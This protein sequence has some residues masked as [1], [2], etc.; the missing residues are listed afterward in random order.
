MSGLLTA[1]AFADLFGP[2]GRPALAAALLPFL[3]RQRWFGGKGRTVAAVEV[4]DAVPLGPA[5]VLA[6]V[7][8]GYA[9]SRSERYAAPLRFAASEEAQGA[10]VPAALGGRRGVLADAMEDPAV[11]RLLL[12]SVLEERRLRG[13]GGEVIGHRT[14]GAP[15]AG[16]NLEPYLLG[17][18]QSNTSVRFGRRCILKLLRRVE[19]GPH[20]DVEVVGFLTA[21]GFRHVPALIGWLAYRPA[22]EPPAAL[23]VVQAYV[24]N[25]GD[26]WT[27]ALGRAQAGL[28]GEADR[29]WPDE[30]ARLGRRTAELHLTLAGGTDPAFSPE[31]FTDAEARAL[32]GRVAAL[33]DRVLAQ[34]RRH[35][36][37]LP[38]SAQV[39]VRALLARADAVRERLRRPLPAGG[40]R[41]RVHGDY[42][43]GQVLVTPEV[44]ADFVLIDFEGEPARPLAERRRKDLPLRD[45]AGMVRSFHY[46]A[47]VALREAGRGGPAGSGAEGGVV[48]P[49]EVPAR[50][51]SWAAES[52]RAFL[53]GYL[54]VAERAPADLPPILPPKGARE[55]LLEVLMVEK[56]IYELGYELDHRPGWAGIPARGILDMLEGGVWGERR[57]SQ[58][59]DA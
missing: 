43:L 1:P 41:T 9:D 20:P 27:Y 21:R 10:V 16:D 32:L 52:A 8:V 51:R 47:E 30:A 25:R 34:A 37:E 13:G 19:P 49:E 4:V 35:L 29:A 28:Q 45:V 6:V 50:A 14:V 18:E 12:A 44:P 56:A 2:A 40:V 55:A 26:G 31:P 7:R 59:G 58:E 42:H 36:G 5:A 38:P 3:Q 53:D 23:A 33:A 24:P 22:G 17:T 15:G 54:T 46:A 39:P 48:L 11:A 57:V